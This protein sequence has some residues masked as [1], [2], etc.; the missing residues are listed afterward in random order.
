M[1]QDFEQSFQI[2]SGPS[3][4]P[5]RRI[6]TTFYVQANQPNIVFAAYEPE[7]V[8]FPA[9]V[10][11]VD[12]YDSIHAPILLDPGLIYSVVSTI[13]ITTPTVL[14]A[15]PAAW[16]KADANRYTQ[17]PVDLPERVVALAERITAS[18]PTTYGKVMAVQDWLHRNTRYNLD[19]PRTLR[20]WMR[21]TSSCSSGGRG[22][23]STSR[24][25]WRCC[26][27]PSVSPRAS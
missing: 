19:I 9:P 6:V 2:P 24:A 15:A 10:L 11:M 22:S 1:G 8:Y 3:D 18:A 7:Q 23:A 20:V 14:R 5:T 26:S 17:L 21:S 13:P 4:V 27:E 16:S 25:P 12:R